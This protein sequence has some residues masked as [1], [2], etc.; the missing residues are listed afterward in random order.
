[1]QRSESAIKGK[2]PI[3]EQRVQ[4]VIRVTLNNTRLPDQNLLTE[5]LYFHLPQIPI[6]TQPPA[7]CRRVSDALKAGQQMET[8]KPEALRES[9]QQDLQE[10][11]YGHIA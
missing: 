4:W 1:M 5:G 7:S 2:G 11:P 9:L 6:K 8:P 3:K 10:N